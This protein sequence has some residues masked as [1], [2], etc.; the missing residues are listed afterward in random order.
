MQSCHDM[1]ACSDRD[2]TEYSSYRYTGQ[3]PYP[4][5]LVPRHLTVMSLAITIRGGLNASLQLCRHSDHK[6]PCCQPPA[7][8]E[9]RRGAEE[10]AYHAELTPI[11]S[12]VGRAQDGQKRSPAKKSD[13]GSG[14]CPQPNAPGF[15]LWI[16]CHFS[17]SEI[18]TFLSSILCPSPIPR[19]Q[20]FRALTNES[21]QLPDTPTE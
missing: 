4:T 2:A 13:C 10:K 11:T 9:A 1:R 7:K 20:P 6:T 19:K 12:P 15:F 3:C 18:F 14:Y 8:E 16:H 17:F 21:W 5:L